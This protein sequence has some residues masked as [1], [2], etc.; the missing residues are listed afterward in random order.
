LLTGDARGD[1]LIEGLKQEGLLDAN[2]KLHVDILK[3][4]HHG[5]DRN[6]DPS[7]FSTITA[8]H[9]LASADGTFGNPDR[10]TLEMLIDK[11][12]K[13]AAYTIHLTYPLA[14]IDARRK[15]EWD[16]DRQKE[17]ADGKPHVRAAWDSAKDDLGKLFEQKKAQGFAFA[18][19]APPAGHTEKSNCWDR[20]PSREPKARP[21]PGGRRR[22]RG[23]A[24]PR[25]PPRPKSAKASSGTS[26]R[27]ALYICGTRQ[28]SASVTVSPNRCRPACGAASAFQRV[29]ALADP[30]PVPVV[31]RRL[32]D[33]EPGEILSTLRLLIGWMSAAIGQRQREDVGIARSQRRLGNCASS[34]AMI[35]RLWVSRSPSAS[36]IGTKPCGLRAR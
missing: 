18:V 22:R 29:E 23:G 30:V 1:Y 3:M 11:R 4:P 7:F 19:S 16:K 25:R 6:V 15:G 33:A 36:S 28:T 9:Y 8:D 27:R 12:G 10:P 31:A 20:S 21:H 35:A 2:G 14:D 24:L 34:Q 17:I 26:K 5:S 32:V 13:D